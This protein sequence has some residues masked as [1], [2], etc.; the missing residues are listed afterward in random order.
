[1]TTLGPR[2]LILSTFFRPTPPLSFTQFVPSFLL[3]FVPFL[4]ASFPISNFLHFYTLPSSSPILTPAVDCLNP[5][6]RD[7]ERTLGLKSL[8]EDWKQLWRQRCVILLAVSIKRREQE[9]TETCYESLSKADNR[10]FEVEKKTDEHYKNQ[11][12]MQEF[13][14]RMRE[15]EIFEDETPED[16]ESDIIQDDCE[17][18]NNFAQGHNQRDEYFNQDHVGNSQSVAYEFILNEKRKQHFHLL[19]EI[20]KEIN[21]ARLVAD[22]IALRPLSS[23]GRESICNDD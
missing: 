4:F 8:A 23:L 3:H 11:N 7:K 9:R 5:T 15:N 22:R 20:E 18:P 16:D 1:M 17:T 21:E 2:S 10:A 19:R 14:H 6:K 13:E 12:V